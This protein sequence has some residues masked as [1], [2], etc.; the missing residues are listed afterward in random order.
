MRFRSFPLAAVGCRLLPALCLAAVL[1]GCAKPAAGPMLELTAKAQPRQL[2]SAGPIVY[3]PSTVSEADRAQTGWMQS[4]NG[5]FVRA[6]LG[7]SAPADAGAA[8]VQLN[9]QQA[10][11]RSVAQ[12]LLGEVLGHP[13]TIDPSIEGTLSLQAN[14]PVTRQAAL[15]LLENAL[16]LSGV[17]M[18]R[19][20]DAFQLVPLDSAAQHAS[21]RAGNDRRSAGYGVHVFS[22]HYVT[23]QQMAE[24][25]RPFLPQERSVTADPARPVLIVSGTG[26]EAE[27]VRNLV[28]TFDVDWMKGMSL[29]AF[30]VKAARPSQLAEELETIFGTGGEEGSRGPVRFVPLDRMNSL[31]VVA[32][33]QGSIARV[34]SLIAQLDRN[35]GAEQ[36]RVY[37]Y[38]VLN[39]DAER[40]GEAMA[41]LFDTEGGSSAGADPLQTQPGEA[42]VTLGSSDSAMSLPRPG[43]SDG[44]EVT[45]ADADAA[46][47]RPALAELNRLLRR[48]EGGSRASLSGAPARPSQ[49]IRIVPDADKN[50]LL[51]LATPNDY[52]L[53]EDALLRLDVQPLQVLVEAT[54]AEVTLTDEFRFGVEWFLK[55]GATRL[56]LSDPETGNVATQPGFSVEIASG[57]DVRVVLDALSSLTTVNVVSA[58]RLLVLDNQKARLQVGDQVPVVT[59]AAQSVT[60]PDAPIV[61]AVELKDT[62]VILEIVPRVGAGGNVTLHVRQEVSDVTQTTTSGID[63]PTIQ[64]RIIESTVSV[65]SGHTVALGGLIR[66]RQGRGQAGVPVL[67]EVPLL[68]NLF[69][70]TSDSNTRTELLVLLTPKVLRNSSEAMEAT[71]ELS[72]QMRRIRLSFE[73]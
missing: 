39:S 28:A 34:G 61:N 65:A 47:G 8:T 26:P 54:I 19:R 69:R 4:G 6:A 68:G 24:L 14:E 15:D 59:Q 30:P 33:A 23:A 57:D 60:D 58:P 38:R 64:Q 55:F 29:G 12:S 18:V 25:V 41:A 22:L 49:A 73:P 36:Q 46:S 20:G 17:A 50:Q 48:Q 56:T 44:A 42:A 16:Q 21:P 7:S 1:G 2:E 40:L 72:R 35:A 71:D 10:D 43:G 3:W 52:A 70:S 9:Y 51:I 11:I 53:V 63:S 62:G 45:G 5:Q 31:L 13:Y 67:S 32:Q 37:V 27:V 66:D